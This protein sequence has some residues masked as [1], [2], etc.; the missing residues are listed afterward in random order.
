MGGNGK[1]ETGFIGE[2]RDL[3]VPG[4]QKRIRGG[5]RNAM[6]EK[7]QGRKKED[8]DHMWWALC[9]PVTR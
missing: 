7:D 4:K 5:G 8:L 2:K 3:N 1:S 6:S 9:L